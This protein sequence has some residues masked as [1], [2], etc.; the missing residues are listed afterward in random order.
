MYKNR[1]IVDFGRRAAS[2]S[3]K[4]AHPCGVGCQF[5]RIGSIPLTPVAQASRVC[6]A[7]SRR[8]RPSK[9]SRMKP[10]SDTGRRSK[11]LRIAQVFAAHAHECVV[12]PILSGN[13]N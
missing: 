10:K 11:S 5:F 9:R 12:H 3:A 1:A 7:R 13:A 4:S 2:M 8:K 6:L